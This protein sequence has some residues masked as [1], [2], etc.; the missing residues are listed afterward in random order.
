MLDMC[1]GTREPLIGPDSSMA[2]ADQTLRSAKADDKEAEV[3][4]LRNQFTLYM[5][6]APYQGIMKELYRVLTSYMGSCLKVCKALFCIGSL[7][8]SAYGLECLP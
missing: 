7:D 8:H 1:F 2:Q 4:T 3:R 6:K 5:V